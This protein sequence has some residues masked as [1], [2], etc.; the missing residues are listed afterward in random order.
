M[1]R[2][3]HTVASAAQACRLVLAGSS[4]VSSRVAA[5]VDESGGT[6]LRLSVRVRLGHQR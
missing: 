4:L 6:G 2:D 5:P 3:A 1:A